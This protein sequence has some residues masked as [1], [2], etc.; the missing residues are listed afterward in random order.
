MASS[1]T[2]IFPNLED[3]ITLVYNGIDLT[4]FFPTSKNQLLR[5]EL[6]ISPSDW[7]V[8]CVSRMV[9]EKR[10]HDVILSIPH[11]ISISNNVKFLFVGDGPNRSELELLAERLGVMNFCRFI[12]VR[13]DMPSTY[14]AMYRNQK[15]LGFP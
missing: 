15:G 9:P 5:T 6:D 8:G 2:N 4:R 7:L 10:V 14:A 1:Y 12:G 13:N 3:K 11:I